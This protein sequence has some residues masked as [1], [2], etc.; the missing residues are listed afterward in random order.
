MLFFNSEFRSRFWANYIEFPIFSDRICKPGICKD[1]HVQFFIHRIPPITLEG[2]FYKFFDCYWKL[3]T[4]RFNPTN[5]NGVLLQPRVKGALLLTQ[6]GMCVSI[7]SLKGFDGERLENR[8]KKI[9]KNTREG[10]REKR[11]EENS[12]SKV[13]RDS[14]GRVKAS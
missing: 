12:R 1:S 11:R 6:S 5:V 9:K 2:G 3:F 7:R 8:K 4:S 14:L 10:G 13:S